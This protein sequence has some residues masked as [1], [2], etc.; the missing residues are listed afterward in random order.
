MAIALAVLLSLGMQSL[1]AAAH[2]HAEAPA[3]ALIAAPDTGKPA[4]Q[5]AHRASD[6]DDC[7]ICRTLAQAQTYL[8]PIDVALALP[9]ARAALLYVALALAMA[10]A[11]RSHGW[12]S[13]APPALSD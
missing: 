12:H 10:M 3:R 4:P 13:R 1:L 7:Q 11:A 2:H 9:M 6:S 8:P 5:P